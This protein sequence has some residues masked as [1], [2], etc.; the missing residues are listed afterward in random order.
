MCGDRSALDFFVPQRGC[1]NFNAKVQI[2]SRSRQVR[3]RSLQYFKDRNIRASAITVVV[4][5]LT[6]KD[7]SLKKG[8]EEEEEE[9]RMKTPGSISYPLSRPKKTFC[10]FSIPSSIFS[11]P[12]WPGV[13]PRLPLPNFVVRK[14]GRKEGEGA[15]WL[16]DRKKGN[17]FSFLSPAADMTPF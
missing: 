10:C 5:E 11:L 4:L 16:R 9:G 3:S 14:K 15:A 7:P 13:R 6:Q 12:F 17:S 2:I 8:E 1:S